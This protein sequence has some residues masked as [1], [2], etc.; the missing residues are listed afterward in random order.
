[1][2]IQLQ[3]KQIYQND[4]LKVE[5]DEKIK[6]IYVEWFKHPDSPD[7]RR[8]FQQLAEMTL[9]AKSKFWLSDARAIHYLEFAD[10]NWLLREMLP[11]LL[12]SDLLKFARLTTEVSLL[13]LDVVRVY[14]MVEQLTQL[15]I[16]TKLELF[17]DKVVAL[18]WLF[19]DIPNVQESK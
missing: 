5:V 1:M 2:H 14:T 8:L 12:K 13:Q 10:Q 4:Y 11:M 16:K 15:G 6:F 9:A 19:D 17:I 18:N 7:F 3:L